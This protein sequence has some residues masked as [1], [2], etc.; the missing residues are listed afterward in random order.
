MPTARPR[1]IDAYLATVP[2]AHR[3]ALRRIRAAVRKAYPEAEESF[4][5]H[6]P[7][8]RLDGKA[9]VAFRSSRAHCSI[10]PLSGTI[11][12]QLK[13]KLA[14]F[15]WSRGTLRF[16]PGKPIPALLLKAIL[17]ARAEEIGL[18]RKKGAARTSP[19]RKG[20]AKSGAGAKGMKAYPDFDAYLADQIPANR[21]IIA[22]LRTFVKRKAPTLQEAVKW[23]NGCWVRGKWPMAYVFSAPAYVQFGFIRGSALK[24]PKGLLEGDGQYVRHVKVRS[25]SDIDERAFSALLQ[26]AVRL[27]HP[28]ER[29]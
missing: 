29:R 16:T 8:F 11:L 23:G 12:P 18:S 21:P 3:P 2:A 19:A 6:L 15:S 27:G 25:L 20:K 5:Y 22:A 10:H 4:Y 1:T 14:G 28:A 13:E 24:D 9:F 17:R 7:A 26:Q